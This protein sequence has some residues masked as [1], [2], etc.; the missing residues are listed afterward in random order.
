[1]I[2]T[3]FRQIALLLLAVAISALAFIQDRLAE[4]QRVIFV[5]SITS[6]PM[7]RII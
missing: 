7:F 1:M 5:N 3:R 6:N 4:M 2:A